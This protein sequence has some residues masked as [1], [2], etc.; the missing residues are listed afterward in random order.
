PQPIDANITRRSYVVSRDEGRMPVI[1]SGRLARQKH[2]DMLVS[3]IE[4]S[5]DIQFD[6]YGSGEAQYQK[7]LETLASKVDNVTLK[8]AFTSFD[9]LPI[10]N[11]AAY[12]FTSLWE[13]MPNTILSAAARGIPIVAADAGG[14]RELINA[15]TGW[16]VQPN[17]LDAHVNALD[18][19][20][21]NPSEAAR[22]VA[23][24]LELV[25]KRHSWANYAK[26]F[27]SSPSFLD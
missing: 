11:Y 20:R 22:R 27:S 1:W 16:L 26:V 3:V 19:I 12:L 25:N 18:E 10:E 7:M 5:P 9:A 17:D 23:N 21:R 24:L 8:G 13:G 6:V 2:I 15:E 14:I 4:R